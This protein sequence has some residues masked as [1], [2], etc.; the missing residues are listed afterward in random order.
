MIDLYSWSTPNGHKVH[1]ML[2]ECG[3]P[4]TPQPVD[5]NRGDQLDAKF[6][7]IS[8]NGRIPAIVDQDGPGGQPLAIAESGAILIYLAEK[9]RRFLPQG[10]ASRYRA[11]QWLM[12]QMSGIGPM[13]GQL[14][15]FRT[16]AVEKLPYAIERYTNEARRLYRVLDQRLAESPYL[17]GDE[18][19]I[20]DI[21]TWPW[22]HGIDRQGH[23]PADYPNVVRWFDTIRERPAVQRGVR[24]FRE[25]RKQQLDEASRE[26]LFG[27]RQFDAT[28]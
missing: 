12:F 17:A 4:Y 3:L 19:T 20:A 13:F 24:L 26:V 8:P 16:D 28:P 22:A 2:E 21:A 27:K 1:I 23:D 9:T 15:H 18:Y 7:A 25:L 5:I 6:R 10:D 14:Y 11:M